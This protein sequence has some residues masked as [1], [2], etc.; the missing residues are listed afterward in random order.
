MRKLHFFTLPIT[1]VNI[2]LMRTTVRVSNKPINQWMTEFID[3]HLIFIGL[4]LVYSRFLTERLFARNSCK[5]L[6]ID[7]DV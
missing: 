4:Y 6:F 5:D 3:H 7:T 2:Y 1:S